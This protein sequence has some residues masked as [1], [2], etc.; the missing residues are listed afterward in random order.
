MAAVASPWPSQ[1]A[2]GGRRR[3]A[4]SGRSWV[5]NNHLNLSAS[6]SGHGA[7]KCQS[8]EQDDSDEY[9]LI[10]ACLTVSMGDSM[11][12]ASALHGEGISAKAMQRPDSRPGLSVSGYS[13]AECRDCGFSDIAA[14]RR[15]RADDWL[16]TPLRMDE[17]SITH[18]RLATKMTMLAASD[19]LGYRPRPMSTTATLSTTAVEDKTLWSGIALKRGRLAAKARAPS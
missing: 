13:H 19:S 17:P 18:R 1:C 7:A 2:R 6:A 3:G 8:G 14:P 4:A 5:V 16:E 11:M 12:A 9:E 15:F 10:R